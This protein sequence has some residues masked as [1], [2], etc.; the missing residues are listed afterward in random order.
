MLGALPTGLLALLLCGLL[1]VGSEEIWVWIY[2]PKLDPQVLAVVFGVTVISVP[3]SL[4]WSALMLRAMGRVQP[5]VIDRWSL[6]Y[7]RV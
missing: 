4:V 7:I 5:G 3:V 1:G 6:A 2:E